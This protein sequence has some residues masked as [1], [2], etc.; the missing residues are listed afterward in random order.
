MFQM[1]TEQL[2]N[3]FTNHFIGRTLKGEEKIKNKTEEKKQ[4]GIA[5]VT[6]TA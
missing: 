6:R 1:E 2:S 3:Y 5:L 4:N